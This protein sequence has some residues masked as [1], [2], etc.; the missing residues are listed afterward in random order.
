[1]E[2]MGRDLDDELQFKQSQLDQSNVT[3]RSEVLT[4][5]YKTTQA[6]FLIHAAIQRF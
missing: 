2:T 4:K 6:V 3:N 1:M 5:L